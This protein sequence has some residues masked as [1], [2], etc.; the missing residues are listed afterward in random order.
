[1]ES[2]VE[3]ML[4]EEGG[5]CAGD[6]APLRVMACMDAIS[7]LNTGALPSVQVTMI[8]A[9]LTKWAMSPARERMATY[10]IVFDLDWLYACAGVNNSD[11]EEALASISQQL[12]IE[13]GNNQEVIGNVECWVSCTQ[14]LFKKIDQLWRSSHAT[15]RITQAIG[16][17][18]NVDR[19]IKRASV[20]GDLYATMQGQ[21][22]DALR[23]RFFTL[24]EN[25]EEAVRSPGAL[26][27]EMAA[28]GMAHDDF[29]AL[30][31]DTL[32]L[33]FHE[34]AP[35]DPGR[36]LQARRALSLSPSA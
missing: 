34:L 4:G 31:D 1:M 15:L 27:Q 20:P 2:Q 5:L 7:R 21:W 19:L 32:A 22:E 8:Q 30:G 11:G 29:I 18:E 26:E 3:V 12:K 10:E 28:L 9:I 33:L 17:V 14:E 24:P 35:M 25:L 16:L 36:V 6:L 13:Y 23:H